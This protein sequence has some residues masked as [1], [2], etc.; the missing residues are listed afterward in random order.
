MFKQYYF[1]WKDAWTLSS[2]IDYDTM[3]D[4]YDGLTEY[5]TDW[6]AD[7][8]R[9]EICYT[10]REGNV[11]NTRKTAELP[12]VLSREACLLENFDASQPPFTGSGY[13]PDDLQGES[14]ILKM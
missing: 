5:L 4:E 2:V 14:D 8:I 10:D 6:T 13:L 9:S 3:P 1:R 12:N 7:A 11:L